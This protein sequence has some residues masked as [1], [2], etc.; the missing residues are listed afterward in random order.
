M[1]WLPVLG[2]AM[3]LGSFDEPPDD[4]LRFE[5][6]MPSGPLEPGRYE[7]RIESSIQDGWTAAGVT[8]PVLQIG[9]PDGVTLEG[10]VLE[11]RALMRN[12]FFQ[13]PYERLLERGSETVAFV[14]GADVAAD[15]A[16]YFNV[17]AYVTQDPEKNAWF[18]RHRYRLPLKPESRSEKVEIGEASWSGREGLRIG[19]KAKPF[20]LPSADG[21]TV[22]LSDHLGERPVIV[23]TYRAYW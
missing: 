22:D 14:V 19:E 1:Y 4:V 2:V 11:G 20:V 10:E 15:A 17:V 6:R 5:A 12:G 9:V 23:T 16:L 3:L 8:S 7:L 13:A 18:V 21:S